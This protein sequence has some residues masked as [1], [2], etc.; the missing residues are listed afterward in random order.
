MIEK[1]SDIIIVTDVDG[2]L[3]RAKKGLSKENLAAIKRFIDKGGRFTVSTGRTIEATKKLLPNVP[4]N[5]L[6]IHINGGYFYDWKTEE[7][8]GQRYISSHAK[9]YCKAIVEKFPDCDCSFSGESG[10]ALMTSGHELKNYVPE[11]EFVFFKGGFEEIP[12]SIYKFV[13]CSKPEK[14]DEVYE[15]ARA[16]CGKDVSLTQS[17]E[18]F[19]E[20]LP[21]ENSKGDSLKKLCEI[22]DIP[23]ENSVAVGDFE[24]DIEMIRIAGVG[25]A[26]DNAKEKVKEVSDIIL[27]SCDDNAIAHLISFLEEMYE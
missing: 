18:F 3:L 22:L 4:F 5:S 1:L 26:V 23:L 6:S 10:V 12:D 20:M 24:N 15:F 9:N 16:V 19:I 25:A 8:F 21:K 14:L 17:S 11:S 2:T 7:V 13:I 27:P